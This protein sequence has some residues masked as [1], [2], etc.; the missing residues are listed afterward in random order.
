MSNNIR[1]LPDIWKY[2]SLLHFT[3]VPFTKMFIL[4]LWELWYKEVTIS[5][6]TVRFLTLEENWLIITVLFYPRLGRW[7]HTFCLILTTINGKK[8]KEPLDFTQYYHKRSDMS[9]YFTSKGLWPTNLISYFNDL[10]TVCPV[11]DKGVTEG[12]SIHFL[13]LYN[14]GLSSL[15]IKEKW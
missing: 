1:V 8:E 11:M 4:Y 3:L 6:T 12:S 15:C 7:S 13:G 2:T 10:L 9:N 14:L 5:I